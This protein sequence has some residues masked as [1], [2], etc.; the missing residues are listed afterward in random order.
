MK[1]TRLTL[2]LAVALAALVTASPALAQ[3]NGRGNGN[4]KDKVRNE[5]IDDRRDRD[6]RWDDDRRRDRD[7]R[8]DRL[9]DGRRRGVPPGWCIGRGNPHNTRENCGYRR[10]HV[11]YD[12]R[13][14][15]RRY[16]DRYDDRRYNDRYGRNSGSYAAR[17]AEF[18][19][20]HDRQ[21]NL[22]A[23][24]RPLDIQWQA[25]VRSECAEIHRDWHRREG[26]SHR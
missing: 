5:R 12:P 6:D 17:H 10:G 18:H 7:R 13:H 14:R 8:S 15:D 3:G 22:R 21:C 26:I 1:T 24:Q 4:A 2:P 11:Y 23:A 25:R 19:R 9:S 16:D 20:V